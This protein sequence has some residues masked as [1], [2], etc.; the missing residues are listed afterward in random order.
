VKVVV[1]VRPQVDH[2]HVQQI[3][4]LLHM[5]CGR[6]KMSLLKVD[7]ILLTNLDF[8]DMYVTTVVQKVVFHHKLKHTSY[9]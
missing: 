7:P 1:C 2:H 8:G 6:S 3:M 5:Y 4:M 9:A